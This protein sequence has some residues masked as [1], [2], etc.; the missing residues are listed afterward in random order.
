MIP[1]NAPNPEG[2]FKYFI[3]ALVD[4]GSIQELF[5]YGIEGIDYIKTEIG[6]EP[7][8]GTGISLEEE[9]KMLINPLFSISR[10]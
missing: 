4:G 1:T 5:S 10:W 9:S 7:I 2:V 6:Y 8:Q 3:E